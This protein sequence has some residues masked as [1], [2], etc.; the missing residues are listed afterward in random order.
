M[1]ELYQIFREEIISILLQLFQQINLEGII[2][3]AFLKATITVAP[4]LNKDV[5]NNENYRPI[6]L[7]NKLCRHSRNDFSKPS[8][9]AH[10]KDY[11]Q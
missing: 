2:T 8:P 5:T 7:I 11:M 1:V 9:T 10:Q 3:Y 6:F 4:K